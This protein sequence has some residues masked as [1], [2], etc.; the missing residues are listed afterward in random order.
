MI[1]LKNLATDSV[2]TL[3]H[4]LDKENPHPKVVLTWENGNQGGK[5]LNDDDPENDSVITEAIMT[6]S[7]TGAKQ[8]NSETFYLTNGRLVEGKENQI[9]FDTAVRG[10]PDTENNN[11]PT[12]SLTRLFRE[13][14]RNVSIWL[15]SE[16]IAVKSLADKF[17]NNSVQI[18]VIAGEEIDA[19]THNL[20]VSLHTDGKYYKYHSENYPNLMGVLQNPAKISAEQN[21]SLIKLNGVSVGYDNLD[22]NSLVYAENGGIITQM[23]S[24]TA[25]ILGKPLNATTV[26]HGEGIFRNSQGQVVF[27]N[28]PK[29]SG[30]PIDEDHFINKKFFEE[31]LSSSGI[32]KVKAGADISANKLVWN[33]GSDGVIECVPEGHVGTMSG[34]YANHNKT[35]SYI[36]LKN[37]Y[38]LI[39]SEN[40]I[41]LAKAT[42]ND[43]SVKKEVTISNTNK[44]LLNKKAD[45]VIT[46]VRFKTNSNIAYGFDIT[47]NE[48]QEDF[49]LGNETT[50][51]LPVRYY[52]ND[53]YL[54]SDK[55]DG[56]G[57][58]ISLIDSVGGGYK[59]RAVFI[60]GNYAIQSYSLPGVPDS[61]L[62]K[63]YAHIWAEGSDHCFFFAGSQN[64]VFKV[65][66]VNKNNG[67]INEAVLTT[68]MTQ[69]YAHTL[70]FSNYLFCFFGQYKLIAKNSFQIEDCQMVNNK[71]FLNAMAS[72]MN[73]T[74]KHNAIMFGDTAICNWTLTSSYHNLYKP[75]MKCDLRGKNLFLTNC[76]SENFYPSSGGQLMPLNR[77]SF[78]SNNASLTKAGNPNGQCIINLG[79]A[80]EAMGVSREAKTRGEEIELTCSNNIH[81]KEGGLKVGE[82]YYLSGKKVGTCLAENTVFLKF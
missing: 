82:D 44:I 11:P 33:A 77:H 24:E 36:K 49:S 6:A 14:R 30:T 47:W 40:H 53:L 1:N 71:D 59:Y 75:I 20:A 28:L 17:R 15:M 58:A 10:I 70:N 80:D 48:E 2:F 57:F 51:S 46:V 81:D 31:N 60:D 78:V 19:T 72:F 76:V 38:F 16:V 74:A 4:S 34:N 39:A 5:R 29:C 43:Y 25:T 67:V 65:F 26:Q 27:G 69:N 32:I 66:K 35:V 42:A 9:E 63:V 55:L 8:G 23:A 73:G 79:S 18:E 12:K 21:F 3:V 61:N 56:G 62:T 41:K 37:D 7:A 22:T 68:N 64:S 45:G 13:H 54:K 50:I 52:S